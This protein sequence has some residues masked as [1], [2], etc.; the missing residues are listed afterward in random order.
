MD[1]QGGINQGTVLWF[2][3][4]FLKQYCE[5]KGQGSGRGSVSRRREH[6]RRCVWA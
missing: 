6:K 4:V 2:R 5:L 3:Y 1:V